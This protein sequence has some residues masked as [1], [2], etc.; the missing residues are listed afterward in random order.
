MSENAINMSCD[1]ARECML[2]RDS[3]ELSERDRDLLNLHLAQCS[4]CSMAHGLL[5]QSMES[6]KRSLPVLEPSAATIAALRKELWRYVGARRKSL[7]WSQFNSLAVAASFMVVLAVGW[8]LVSGPKSVSTEGDH[9]A[10]RGLVS[11]AIQIPDLDVRQLDDE[12]PDS[13]SAQDFAGQ[14]MILEDLGEDS[15]GLEFMEQVDEVPSSTDLRS[16]KN[17]GL[18]A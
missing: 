16:N 6:I 17:C 15:N 5:V 8:W 10:M 14:L 11:V 12:P 9:N 7:Y 4:D 1:L 18:P 13:V 2:L 3:G